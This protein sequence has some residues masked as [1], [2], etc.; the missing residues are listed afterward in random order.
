MLFFFSCRRRHTRCSLVTGVQ[1]CALP[2]CLLPAG[3][4]ACYS[5]GTK[6]RV[7]IGASS[8]SMTAIVTPAT[9]SAPA[10]SVSIA[11]RAHLPSF[12]KIG[13][14][15]CRERVSKYVYISEGAGYLNKKQI[16][17]SSIQDIL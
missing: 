6:S 3:E 4:I 16:L 9:P 12:N 15:S 10:D 8:V 5:A 7:P 11:A 1:T 13:R 14:E 17:Q 2:I